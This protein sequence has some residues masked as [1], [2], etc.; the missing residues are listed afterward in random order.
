MSYVTKLRKIGTFAYINNM[1]IIVGKGS[2][3]ETPPYVTTL[4]L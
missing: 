3:Y 4:S 1:G 2:Y